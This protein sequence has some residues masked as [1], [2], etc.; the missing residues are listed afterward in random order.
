MPVTG[1]ARVRARARGNVP[2]RAAGPATVT[3]APVPGS[4]ARGRG[5]RSAVTTGHAGLLTPAFGE[6]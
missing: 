1:T 6:A 4:A 5:G 3:G 2:P